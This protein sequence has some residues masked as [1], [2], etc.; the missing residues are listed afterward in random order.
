MNKDFVC[1]VCPRAKQPRLSFP[2]ILYCS[3][4]C[5]ELIHIDIWG[6]FSIP[7]KNGSRFFLNIVDDYSRC[8]W[9]YL[10]KHKFETFNVLI[11]FFNQINHQFNTK[12]SH[13]NI[14]SGEIF[15]PQ[16]QTVC[17]DNGTEFLSKQIQTLFHENDIITNVLAL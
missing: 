17:S 6:P 2:Q 1:D 16:L 4:H 13:I 12:I 15:L 14:G 5:F 11:H 9:I 7:S 8:T 3:S 10:M